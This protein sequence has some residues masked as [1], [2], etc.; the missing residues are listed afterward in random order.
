VPIK[1]Y[2]LRELALPSVHQRARP[3]RQQLCVAHTTLQGVFESLHVVRAAAASQPGANGRGRLKEGEVDLLR[4]AVVLAGAGLDAVLRRLATDALPALLASPSK[5]PEAAREFR[6]H[7]SEQVRRKGA[8]KSWIEAILSDDPRPEMVRLYVEA[9]TK[10]SL[11][12][13]SDLKRL[14]DALGL[15]PT[16]VSDEK[17]ASLKGFLVARNQVAHDLDLKRP[18]DETRGNR[19]TRTVP[20]VLEQCD[21]VVKLTATYVTAVSDLLKRKK[22]SQ[23]AP[24]IPS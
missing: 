5:H 15:R 17:I 21:D 19:Y 4:C 13:E 20:K 12:N 9:L 18:G 6:K 24:L 7:V 8:P 16:V 23:P 14:R 2:Q 22:A 10:S 11:Q 3:A 1:K